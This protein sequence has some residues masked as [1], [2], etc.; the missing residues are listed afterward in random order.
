MS[1]PER[2]PSHAS[3]ER[4]IAVIG[5]R[6]DAK[7][8][9]LEKQVSTEFKNIRDRLDA[10]DVQRG[11]MI[12][13][14]T[15]IGTRTAVLESHEDAAKPKPE[16]ITPA[17][18]TW[19]EHLAYLLPFALGLPT[20]LVIGTALISAFQHFVAIVMRDAQ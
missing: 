3:L 8:E 16:A 10:G 5:A 18:K 15:D 2:Q 14:L 9:G 6:I 12:D 4:D 13:Q 11:R 1:P 20:I 7:L 17:R 19:R